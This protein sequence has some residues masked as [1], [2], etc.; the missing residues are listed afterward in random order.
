MTTTHNDPTHGHRRR[1]RKLS[2]YGRELA[3]VLVVKLLAL[4]VI[5]QLWF[6]ASGRPLVDPATIAAR[7]HS[8]G[9]PVHAQERH[10]RP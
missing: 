9:A 4:A 1:P 6:A 8:S 7:V 5:W 3:V 10:A 2:R